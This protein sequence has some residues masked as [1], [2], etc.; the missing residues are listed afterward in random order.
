M[1]TS[2]TD[3]NNPNFHKVIASI[4]HDYDNLLERIKLLEKGIDQND[5]QILQN[6]KIKFIELV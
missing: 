3:S 1:S 4:S 6:N 2:L 5:L